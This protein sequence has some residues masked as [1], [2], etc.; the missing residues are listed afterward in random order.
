M[1]IDNEVKNELVKTLATAGATAGADN[2]NIPWI[3]PDV[4]IRTG[5]KA[6]KKQAKPV[7]LNY[8]KGFYLPNGKDAETEAN[9]DA[10]NSYKIINEYQWLA[11]GNTGPTVAL[12]E[13]AAGKNPSYEF[14]LNSGAA[15]K[16][17]KNYFDGDEYT[18][19][20][21]NKLPKAYN[22]SEVTDGNRNYYYD[23]IDS[24]IQREYVARK[25]E[26][27]KK[28]GKKVQ[29]QLDELDDKFNKFNEKFRHDDEYGPRSFNDSAFKDSIDTNMWLKNIKNSDTWES[30]EKRW[31]VDA[32]TQCKK[33]VVELYGKYQNLLDRGFTEDE[34]E[35]ELDIPYG[36]IRKLKGLAESTPAT[37][38]EVGGSIDATTTEVGQKTIGELYESGDVEGYNKSNYTA[39]NLIK[40]LVDNGANNKEAVTKKLK[41]KGFGISSNME[42]Q[43][44]IYFP[45]G[46]AEPV[47]AK[48]EAPV[49]SSYSIAELVNSNSKEA[50]KL[51]DERLSKYERKVDKYSNSK[52][53]PTQILDDIF[54]DDTI[55]DDEKAVYAF[56]VL[57][58]KG[59]SDDDAQSM[60]IS[61]LNDYN[62][63]DITKNFVQGM[64]DTYLVIPNLIKGEFG[65][66]L[67]TEEKN[68]EY[69]PAQ[70]ELGAINNSSY[71]DYVR[72]NELRNAQ[73][74]K[75]TEEEQRNV[76]KE[77]GKFSFAQRNLFKKLNV[78][79]ED[80]WTSQTNALKEKDEAVPEIIKLD[81]PKW[82]PTKKAIHTAGFLLLDKFITAALNYG[83]GAQGQELVKSI[84]EERVAD[85]KAKQ[86]EALSQAQTLSDLYEKNPRAWS[87]YMLSLNKNLSPENLKAMYDV[88][89]AT[90]Y[91]FN[92]ENISQLS[93][94][95]DGK[96]II[97]SEIDNVDSQIA[98]YSKLRNELANSEAVRNKTVAELASLIKNSYS[99]LLSASENT[100]ASKGLTEGAGA[101]DTA[102][103]TENKSID[104]R[105]MLNA[106]ADI[107][108][109]KGNINASLSG[110]KSTGK[111]DTR[112]QN[113]NKSVNEQEN[114]GK[115][116][117]TDVAALQVLA[118]KNSGINEAGDAAVK[119]ANVLVERLDSIIVSLKARKAALLDSVEELDTFKPA[120][121]AVKKESK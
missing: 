86:M 48:A 114:Y 88:S 97:Y 117:D 80:D 72:Y 37:A 35:R 30:L 38:P 53:T 82:V 62:R 39:G 25:Q 21:I 115:K 69:R 118:E 73:K 101:T 75:L 98:E 76:Q 71:K 102:N 33:Q 11:N 52:K 96:N 92:K 22:Y 44:D 49:N 79:D 66:E 54:E 63:K 1:E 91:E 7:A 16:I 4:D 19:K 100:G 112:T 61:K 119:Y 106:G 78:K 47:N 5:Q 58:N 64:L 65:K 42:K 18:N 23:E 10:R 94:I 43:L 46:S 20:V 104:G 13:E 51:L 32:T 84:W 24:A 29:K 68:R 105:V 28:S 40:Y 56:E 116:V 55:S 57:H 26:L 17:A 93:S 36:N 9:K 27:S 108:M 34:A 60:L 111:S 113:F 31:G 3:D 8:E 59:I 50:E 2:K 12:T 77:M 87:S 103:T 15:D 110:G 99:G 6:E 70:K 95:N 120:N 85:N 74:G 121:I 107:K 67:K 90:Q 89:A 14:T 109:V 45:E 41:E 83:R 81:E